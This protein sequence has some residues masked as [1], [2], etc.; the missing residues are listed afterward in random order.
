[1]RKYRIKI[2]SLV[3]VNII[4]QEPAILNMKK[5]TKTYV[6]TPPFK[7]FGQTWLTATAWEL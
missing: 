1:M 2:Q 4:N 6:R 3:A 7:L 5:G